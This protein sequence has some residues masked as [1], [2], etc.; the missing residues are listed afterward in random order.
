LE[1]KKSLGS[2]AKYC[3]TDLAE[4]YRFFDDAQT[5]IQEKT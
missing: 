3:A 1:F 2:G 4:R 5:A